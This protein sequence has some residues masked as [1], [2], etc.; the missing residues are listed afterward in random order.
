MQRVLSN[1]KQYIHDT[2][3]LSVVT[4]K[5]DDGKRMPFFLQD[6]YLFY[7]TQLLGFTCLLMLDIRDQEESPAVIRKHME[8]VRRKWNGEIVYV[9]DTMTAYNRKRLIEQK[10]PFIVPGNQL[11]LPMLAIDLREY[12]RRKLEVSP[13]FSPSTQVLVLHWIYSGNRQRAERET[14]T[15]L[16]RVLGYSKMTMTRAFREVKSA[17]K[18]ATSDGVQDVDLYNLDSH[19]LWEKTSAFMRSPVK[20]RLYVSSFD[21]DRYDILRAGLSALADYSMLAKPKNKVL[22]VSQEE[23][24][25]MRQKHEV[26]FLDI[27]EPQTWEIEIWSY[28]PGLFGDDGLVDRLSLYLSLQEM[29]DE[30]VEAALEKLL[31][32]MM[33]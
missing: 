29:E 27:S 3:T 7:R 8:Q 14:A 19:E 16:A 28:P 25:K 11:Y 24:K 1:L 5:W 20:K 4:E 30:R 15:E 12:F 26:P 17:L 10:I 31:E 9:R 6:I 33:W 23:W 18:A 2:L 13:Y 21:M 22:A 32:G